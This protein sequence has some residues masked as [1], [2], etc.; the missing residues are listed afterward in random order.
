MR[1]SPTEAPP[2][3]VWPPMILH[4]LDALA[5][6]PVHKV[7]VVVDIGVI[8]SRRRSST[9]RRARS[10]SSS[11]SRA[12]SSDGRRSRRGSHRS[13]D[14]LVDADGDVVVLPATR[15]WCARHT[16]GARS[17]SPQRRPRHVAHRRAPHPTGYDGWCGARTTPWCASSKPPTCAGRCLRRRGGH[18]H[19]LFPSRRAGAG[20]APA[21]TRGPHGRALSHRYLRRAP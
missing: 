19:P 17:P 20:A 12:R 8:G 16:G 10:P 5:E 3:V 11:S 14:G 18:H 6:L 13:S 4:V 21:A 1:S 2:P 7:V 9:T 15:R